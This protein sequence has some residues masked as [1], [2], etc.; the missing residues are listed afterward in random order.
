MANVQI[1]E[2]ITAE[3]LE[4]VASAVENIADGDELRILLSSY[5]GDFG[6][7]LG[8]IGVLRSKL[9][10]TRCDVVGVAASSAAVL[11]LACDE[12]Y[13][14]TLGALMLHSCF[15]L[16]GRTDDGI[17]RL[18]AVQMSIIQKRAPSL[19]P[20]VLMR[21][22]W[23]NPQEAQRLG[24]VDGILEPVGGVHAAAVRYMAI[25]GGNMEEQNTIEQIEQ[26]EEEKQ[27]ETAEAVQAEEEQTEADAL[28]V[29][30]KLAQQLIEI[31]KRLQV[32][33]E[34]K[35]QRVEARARLNKLVA[36]LAMPQASA[37]IG[38]G[39]QSKAVKRID[40]KKYGSFIKG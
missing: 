18:N 4:R 27:E 23:F 20:D 32:L 21:D 1:F 5:G 31:E 34:Q 13:V 35:E 9:I 39:E 22:T 8:I 28:T 40:S 26:Q 14:D 11:A 15:R 10:R 16:D 12:C 2:D 30:E 38:G 25:I 7:T 37:P 24:L 29:L 6:A 19:S 36:S 3:T 17:E 33:E